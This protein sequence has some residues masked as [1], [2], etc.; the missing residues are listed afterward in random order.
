MFVVSQIIYKDF[1]GFSKGDKGMCGHTCVHVVGFCFSVF[2][3]VE[4]EAEQMFI[5][6]IIN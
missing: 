1:S 6:D 4:S 3:V 5:T 2:V